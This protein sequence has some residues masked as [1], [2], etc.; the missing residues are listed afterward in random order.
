MQKKDIASSNREVYYKHF[1]KIILRNSR[2]FKLTE[3]AK[4]GYILRIAICKQQELILKN[5]AL[6]QV[7]EKSLNFCFVTKIE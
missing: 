7:H 5:I 4:F 2:S 3:S 1:K 6:M